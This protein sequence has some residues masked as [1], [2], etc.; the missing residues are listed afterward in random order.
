MENEYGQRLAMRAMLAKIGCIAVIVASIGN[1]GIYLAQLT[2]TIDIYY[3]SETADA[4]QPN[5]RG[6]LFCRLLRQRNPRRDVD[7]PRA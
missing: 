1:L 3:L 4:C 2:G 5:V 7:P 6:G